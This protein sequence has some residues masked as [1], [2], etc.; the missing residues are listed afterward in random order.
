MIK[1]GMGQ[2]SHRFLETSHKKCLLGGVVVES[3]MGFD[4]DSDGDIIFHSICNAITS[5]THIPIMGGLAIELCKK[6]NITD[7][8]VYLNEALKTLSGYQI[9]HVAITIE[10][11]KPKLQHLVDKIR[12]NISDKLNVALEDVGITVTSG[13]GLSRFSEGLGMH[14]NCLLTVEKSKFRSIDF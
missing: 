3:S 8:A 9:L 10:A 12:K 6:H 13:N 4:A 14:A 1:V 7:S 5:I 2:D 11:G